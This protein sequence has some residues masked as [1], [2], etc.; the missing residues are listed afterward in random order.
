MRVLMFTNAA[1]RGQIPRATRSNDVPYG[2]QETSFGFRHAMSG[3]DTN[4]NLT[5]Y[6]ESCLGQLIAMECL[7]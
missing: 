4:E 2:M 5:C 3:I 6:F 7:T 1:I